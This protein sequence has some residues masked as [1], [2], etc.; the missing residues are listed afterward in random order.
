MSGFWYLTAIAATTGALFSVATNTPERL[1]AAKLSFAS[2]PIIT[3][4]TT[5]EAIA[6]KA[7]ATEPASEGQITSN[8]YTDAIALANQAV[9]AYQSAQK[10]TDPDR[11]ITF[12][13]REQLLWQATLHIL[14]DIPPTD[15]AYEQAQ[16]K[17]QQY[18]GLLA[19]AQ[20][21]LDIA[22]S[23]FL[24]TIIGNAGLSLDQAH[25]SL[26]EIGAAANTETG[27]TELISDR[28]SERIQ[29]HIS[30]N[31]DSCRH[32]QGDQLMASPAS[33]IKL[34]IAI[35]LMD[36]AT[37]EDISL[38]KKIYIDPQN[39]T[40][41]AEGVG[42][43]VD[44]EYA[45]AQVMT[46]MLNESNNIATNQLIDYVG[47]KDIAK[48]MDDRGYSDTLV[49]HKLAGDRIL[50]P[51]PGTQ[52]NQATTNDIT[53]MMAQIYGLENPGD[54]DLLRALYSQRDHE[55]G[56]Q[57]L[58]ELNTELNTEL[59]T[60]V[61]SK[62]KNPNIEWLGEKTGQNDRMIGTVLAMKVGSKR[63]ALTVALDYSSDPA[64]IRDIVKDI[65]TYLLEED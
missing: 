5:T 50:P 58:Q 6:A 56:H 55:L 17:Y 12:T 63:Y 57:A 44:R 16:T 9:V 3:E 34:P 39:F 59:S 22:D 15:K 20:S 45:I 54:E 65:A 23:A 49:D 14:K 29:N 11:R 60:K 13:R 28:I 48:T 30:T 31:D 25:I 36:K 53:R 61:S 40:E 41:N 7:I 26:C 51:N 35:A 1:S 47:R 33:L 10:E 8:R 43:E 2:Q 38:S 64:A 19:T 62:I 24:R 32:H 4:A 46:R 42:I 21:K 52:S 18:K 27:I 37:R